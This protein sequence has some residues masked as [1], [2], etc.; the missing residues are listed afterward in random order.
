MLE[1]IIFLEL[2]RRRYKVFVSKVNKVE[3]D[4][5]AI[6]DG[7]TKYYQVA[8]NVEEKHVLKRELKSL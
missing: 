6:K 5:V 8:Q 1:N 2:L 7:N 4:F 3:I